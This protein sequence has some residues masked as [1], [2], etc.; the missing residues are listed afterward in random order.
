MDKRNLQ[1]LWPGVPLALG[2]AFL[3]GATA[4]ASKILLD[5]IDPQLL[6]GV[7]Y[8]GAGVGLTAIRVSQMA[9]GA[10]NREAPLRATDIPWLAAIVIFGGVIGPLL[11]MMGLSKTDATSGSLLLNLEGLATLGLAWLLFR[12][13]VDRKLIFGAISIMFGAVVL[14]WNGAGFGLDLGAI[15]IA[16][17]CLAW[18][19]DNNLTLQTVVCGRSC[20][21]CHQGAGGRRYQRKHCLHP[22]R[23]GASP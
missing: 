16:G 1:H 7:L 10:L 13:H 14:S 11:L 3:F 9:F 20:D 12:E 23:N 5:D 8:L 18:G 6:A 4:P 15:L 21:R 22:R 2:S 17:A 19:L